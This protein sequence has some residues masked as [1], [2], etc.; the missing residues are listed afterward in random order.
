[1]NTAKGTYTPHSG[2]YRWR[3]Q[4]TMCEDTGELFVVHNKTSLLVH[5]I[6]MAAIF[7][8]KRPN[9]GIMCS[10]FSGPINIEG[11]TIVII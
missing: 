1:M 7:D 11:L 10:R 6:H 5:H 2:L 3:I 8:V 4:T 9:A